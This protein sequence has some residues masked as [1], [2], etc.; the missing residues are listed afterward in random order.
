MTGSSSS[1]P[2]VR[3]ALPSA[4]T[5]GDGTVFRLSFEPPLD[6]GQV[7][8]RWSVRAGDAHP[9]EGS[10]SFTVGETAAPAGAGPATTI[11]AQDTGSAP[12]ESR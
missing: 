6:G 4:V 8:V 1:T 2:P 12:A 9:I 3:S 10:F 11:P 7:G 5:T